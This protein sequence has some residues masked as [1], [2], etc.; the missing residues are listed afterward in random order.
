MGGKYGTHYA[1]IHLEAVNTIAKASKKKS[2]I[3]F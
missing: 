1:G 3:A 2:L